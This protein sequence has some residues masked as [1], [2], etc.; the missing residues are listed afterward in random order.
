MA[1]FA[2]DRR[3]AAEFHKPKR[4]RPWERVLRAPEGRHNLAQRGSAGMTSQNE[5]PACPGRGGISQ[6]DFC[7]RTIDAAPA[8]AE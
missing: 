2:R 5:I 6:P 7:K 1:R 3:K 4:P 8:G